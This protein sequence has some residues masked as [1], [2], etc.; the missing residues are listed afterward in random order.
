MIS[1]IRRMSA[2]N[3]G[4]FLT[5]GASDKVSF[6]NVMVFV[7]TDGKDTAFDF[8]TAFAREIL[9]NVDKFSK[10]FCFCMRR[11]KEAREEVTCYYA[12]DFE[13]T[14]NEEETEVW[15][16][17]FAKVVDYDKLDTFTVNTSLED[18]LKALYL[19]LDKTYTETGED[20]YII[21]FHN[22]KFD[23][24]FL[25]SFFLNNDIECTYFIN[26][27]GVWY[28]ITLEFPDFTLTFRDSLKI[29]NFSIATMAGLF[30]MP[31][32]K[33]ERLPF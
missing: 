31:N 13:T 33:K 9:D 23:G 18:F 8:R 30:K 28:S 11:R 17:C 6:D 32:C 7:D 27:M 20:E 15:L 3:F 19:D 21:F 14:T 24:S 4:A 2:S 22:L 26:D 1:R 5:G 29:L 10:Q 12:G 25:L 16:S